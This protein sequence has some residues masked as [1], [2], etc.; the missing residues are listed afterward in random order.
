MAFEIREG[1]GVYLRDGDVAAGAVRRIHG[2]TGTVTIF[3]E[4]SGEFD[5][6]ASAIRHVTDDKVVLNPSL[7]PSAIL[8]ALGHAHDAEDPLAADRTS[9]DEAEEPA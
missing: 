8:S 2:S 7:L 5:V 4:N 3:I 9:E 1:F 6:P